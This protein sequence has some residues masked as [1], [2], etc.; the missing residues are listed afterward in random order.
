M[1]HGLR[2]TILSVVLLLFIFL[3]QSQINYAGKSFLSDY[4]QYVFD[5]ESKIPVSSANYVYQTS[6]K[7]I[8]I[9]SY[10]GLYRYD[11]KS[12]VLL[13]EENYKFPSSKINVLFEDSSGGLWI[14]TNDVGIVLYKE[15]EFQTI[16]TKQGL[17]SNAIREF[18]EDLDGNIYAATTLGVVKI[19][20]QLNVDTS[21]AD[22]MGIMVSDIICTQQ[23]ELWCV[24]NDGKIIVIEN[25]K[26]I[27]TYS[28]NFESSFNACSIFE[29]RDGTVYIGSSQRRVLRLDNPKQRM[30]YQMFDTGDCNWIESF[31]EDSEG[32]IWIC[33]AAG[34]GYI[35]NNRFNKISGSKID[36]SLSN[37]LQDHEGNY[38][39][40]SSRRGVACFVPS[41]FHNLNF[42]AGLGE[43][44]VNSTAF[45]GN[46]IYIG[47]DQGLHIIDKRGQIIE[48][49]LTEM[50]K[51]N[52]IQCLIKDSKNNLWICTYMEYGVIRYND[53]TKEIVYFNK[54]DKGLVND[55][56]NFVAE[57]SD[58]RMIVGTDMGV[59]IIKDEEVVESYSN[60]D[61]MQNS[62]MLSF[63]EDADNNLYIGSDGGGIYKITDE[64]IDR[65]VDEEIYS[66]VIYSMCY[67]EVYGG[68]WIAN[69]EYISF[70][71]DGKIRKTTYF[72]SS[73]VFDLKLTDDSTMLALTSKGLHFLDRDNL[74]NKGNDDGHEVMS[75][76]D[77][78]L[79]PITSNSLSEYTKDG[80]LYLA[81]SK[82]VYSIDTKNYYVNQTVPIVDIT[83]VTID[84]EIFDK[85]QTIHI[86]SDAKRI[87]I[88]FALL[89]Y[90]RDDGSAIQYMLKGFDKE[91]ITLPKSNDLKVS[92]T[93]LAGGKYKF[94]VNGINGD[95]YISDEVTIEIK[96]ELKFTER[97][98]AWTIMVALC[99]GLF[100]VSSYLFANYRTK[101]MLI[102]QNEYRTI[103]DQAIKAIADTIDAKDEYTAG[104]SQR[105][106][107]YSLRIGKKMGMK[108]KKLED[109]Y[110][111][112]LLHDIGKVG[113]PDHILKKTGVLNEEE[114]N[115]IKKHVE[116][117]GAILKSI[118]IIDDIEIG[119]RYHHEKYDGSGYP[120]G[121]TGEEIPLI[122]RIICVA[123]SFDAMNTTRSYREALP[124]EYIIDEMKQCSG[125]QFDA[126]IVK[127]MMEVIEEVELDEKYI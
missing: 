39:L 57:I 44:T 99:V 42:E 100:G 13:D 95:G 114:F 105:V 74:L 63:A 79:S 37:I 49:D 47:S 6:D 64:G 89:T 93:N 125:K 119:A 115:E 11:G 108:Q 17:P 10:D 24:T 59:S 48:N 65:F 118:T 55:K 112:A 85:P 123:D 91:P 52:R 45:F 54:K 107:D 2:K 127:L 36:V 84:D 4:I 75:K 82:G 71:K 94:I 90:H 14:G 104:H 60:K 53:V 106:A 31:F 30:K 18:D 109:L 69:G 26:K 15:G 35:E 97:K 62:Y 9:A 87:T 22:L 98:S 43:M 8:W 51:D 78:L 61:G 101:Q 67:D 28:S 20:T 126:R 38:W 92:Y 3:L 103:T 41:K 16:G 68:I 86:P 124:L 70:L 33:S 21:I 76:G 12:S 72:D 66:G 113:V 81:C 5:E 122:A 117:G 19:D 96:K 56:T 46:K 40:T 83:S 32:R 88:D 29:S 77:G 58:G 23:N 110:Y 25:N 111:T 116:V 50:L 73:S 80:M 102:R 1:R 120:E 7:Y 121:R 34:F 27:F